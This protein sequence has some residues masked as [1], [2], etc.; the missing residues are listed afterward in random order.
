MEETIRSI[1]PEAWPLIDLL[2]NITCA[3]TAVWLAVSV[4]IWWR[5]S[6]SNLT[7][8]SSAN[9][10]KKASPDFLK[11]DAKARAEAIKR[12]ERFDQELE[13]R[14]REEARDEKRKARAS[15]PASR[16]ARLISLV[17]AL[18]SLATMVSGTIFQV[19]IMGAYW[20]K[21]S[22]SER[23][24]KM[25]QEYPLGVA[26]TIFVIGYNLV[27]FFTKRKWEAN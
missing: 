20:E 13:R 25:V 22:A 19:S 21:Y 8:L 27:I 1:P 2:F 17:M 15:H 16:W 10:N 4:F 11:V 18:F 5:R 26:V 9:V 23:I 14:E 3:V 12:G 7:T 24:L 6:A